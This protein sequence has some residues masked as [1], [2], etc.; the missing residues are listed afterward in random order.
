MVRNQQLLK[1]YDATTAVRQKT[2]IVDSAML[3]QN[4][5]PHV[6]VRSR[7]VVEPTFQIQCKLDQTEKFLWQ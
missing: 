1:F 3:E 4:V 2:I 7:R 6:E 5:M